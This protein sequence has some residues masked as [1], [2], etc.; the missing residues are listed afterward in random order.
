M[1]EKV[2]RPNSHII[3]QQAE[4]DGIAEPAILVEP[5]ND[6]MQISQDGSVINLNYK[7]VDEFCKVLRKLKKQN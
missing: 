4:E 1:I 2:N 6:V 3:W 7:S 5:Y